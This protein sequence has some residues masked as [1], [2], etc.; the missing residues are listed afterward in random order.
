MDPLTRRWRAVCEIAA[1]DAASREVDAV[2]ADLLSRWHESHR[3]Y[4]DTTHLTE[5][6]TAVD[7]L[8]AGGR[9]RDRSA[10]T[11]ALLAGWFHDAIYDPTPDAAN[12]QESA[13]LA[14]EE[15]GRLGVGGAV[16]DR[17]CTVVL[18]TVNHDVVAGGGGVGEERLVFHDADLWVLGA[19]VARFDEYC[20]QVRAEFAQVAT[21]DYA[22]AR[23]AVLRTFLVRPHVYLTAHARREWESRAKENLARE[24]T[25]LA[26]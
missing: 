22:V 1:P 26:G 18:D 10:R 6:L 25:R 8:C 21:G 24:V 20:E 23:T 11:L 13:D 7:T 4:H 2:G 12:E 9:L 15:L 14:R 16:V 3:H 5:V 19:P 17:V